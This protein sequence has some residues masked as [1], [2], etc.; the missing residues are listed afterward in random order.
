MVISQDNKKGRYLFSDDESAGVQ[1][2]A[3]DVGCYAHYE[4]DLSY[5]W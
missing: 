4:S 5:M 3:V 2:T 1:N